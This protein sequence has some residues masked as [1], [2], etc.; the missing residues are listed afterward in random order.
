MLLDPGWVT[1][2][3]KRA[4]KSSRVMLWVWEIIQSTPGG[5]SLLGREQI[6]AWRVPGIYWILS[7]RLG[8]ML[9]F[10]TDPNGLPVSVSSIELCKLL[11]V[12]LDPILM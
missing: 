5:S 12:Y 3:A 8:F 1:P 6:D 10:Q 7:F 4:E 11:G 9:I 2:P